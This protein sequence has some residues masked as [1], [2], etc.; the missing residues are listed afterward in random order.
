M[1]L[2]EYTKI[3]RMKDKNFCSCF[4]SY[5]KAVKFGHK[6]IDNPSVKSIRVFEVDLSNSEI[7]YEMDVNNYAK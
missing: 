1:Y 3:Y 5:E 7:L 4:Y 2:V 6:L